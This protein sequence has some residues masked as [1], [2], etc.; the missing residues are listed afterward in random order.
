MR[1]FYPQSDDFWVQRDKEQEQE[2]LKPG[3][4]GVKL[5]TEEVLTKVCD[6]M[7]SEPCPP[8]MKTALTHIKDNE[9]CKQGAQHSYISYI[10]LYF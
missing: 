6:E 1:T 2:K 8:S 5:I 10:F 9:E 7:L 4:P 3:D